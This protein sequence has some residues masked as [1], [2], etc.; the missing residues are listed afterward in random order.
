VNLSKAR[1]RAGFAVSGCR[2]GRSRTYRTLG[3]DDRQ[4]TGVIYLTII[5][6]ANA[7]L[8]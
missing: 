5:P 2:S 8:L 3:K 4:I 1:H 6:G 7:I